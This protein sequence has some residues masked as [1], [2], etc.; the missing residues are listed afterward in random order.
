MQNIKRLGLRYSYRVSWLLKTQPET[1]SW[2]RGTLGLVPHSHF[3]GNDL[4]CFQEW[5]GKSSGKFW[6]VF[7]QVLRNPMDVLGTLWGSFWKSSS[8]LRE[9][10]ESVNSSS[11]S[12][13]ANFWEAFRKL[14]WGPKGTSRKPLQECSEKSAANFLSRILSFWKTFRKVLGNLQITSWKFSGIF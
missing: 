13:N 5:S 3:S 2:A 12:S 6:F 4:G 10:M 11:G 1:F 14:P 9:I 7:K 8:K